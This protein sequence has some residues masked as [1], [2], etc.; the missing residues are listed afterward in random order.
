M[1][2]VLHFH[3]VH[4]IPRHNRKRLYCQA[5]SFEA[6]LSIQTSLGRIAGGKRGAEARRNISIRNILGPVK[7]ICHIFHNIY[8]MPDVFWGIQLL[9]LNLGGYRDSGDWSPVPVN[10]VRRTNRLVGMASVVWMLAV[11]TFLVLCDIL[12]GLH[13][14]FWKSQDLLQVLSV[15][16]L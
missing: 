10:R 5:V 14:L 9:W 16:G 2:P 6:I 7:Y 1:F 3:G 15:T 8:H 4:F 12:P 13:V 11:V